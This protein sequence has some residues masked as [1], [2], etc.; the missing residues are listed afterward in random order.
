MTKTIFAMS[1]ALFIAQ[2]Q[3]PASQ[4]PAPQQP[5]E[6]ATAIAGDGGQPPRLAVPDFIALSAD[7]ETVAIARIIGQV[8]WDDL[9]Y[10]REFLF[11]PRDVYATIP[12][13]ASLA[14]IPFDRW[15]ELNA[16]GLVTG[17]VQKTGNLLRVEVRLFNVRGRQSVFGKVYSGS[18]ANPRSYAHMAADEIYQTQRA[19]KGVAQSK[20]TFVSDRDGELMGGTVER[21]D[22]KE[23]YISDYDGERQQRVTVGKTLNVFPRWS[24]NGRSIAYTSYRRGTPN[25]FVSNIYEATMEEVTKGTAEN[26]L[27]AWSPDGSKFCF[28]SP[29]EGKGYTNLYMVNR[30]GSGLLKL[31]DHPSINTSP[32]WSPSGTQ[33]AFVSD[34]DRHAADLRDQ[35]RRRRPGATDHDVGRLRGQADVVVI[36]LQRD[37]VH[38]ADR[39]RQRHQDHRYGDADGETTD[40]RRGHER[41]PRC[42][43]QMAG[44]SRSRPRD[45]ARSRFSRSR[46]TG[47]TSGN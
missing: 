27:P 33:I 18:P 3:P 38:R 16:D 47:G 24:P 35:L 17:T 9:N 7:A 23:V 14:E 30:D 31:T 13:A 39:P 46:E 10:E 32:T 5:T 8:L 29:R 44:T 4:Q 12:K 37:C 22:V 2:Q 15:R 21:R 40:V 28:A 11:I 6:V 26:W 1:M 20:L 43:R 19:L 45:R 42:S 36:A 34:Q 41:E 25:I